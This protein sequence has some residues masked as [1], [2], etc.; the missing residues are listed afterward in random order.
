MALSASKCPSV[1][2]ND[3]QNNLIIK[4]IYLHQKPPNHL[5]T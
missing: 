4:Y 5:I 1:P 3:K 2:A